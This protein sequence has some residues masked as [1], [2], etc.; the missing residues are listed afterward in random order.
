MIRAYPESELP[1]KKLDS[2]ISRL[3]DQLKNSSNGLNHVLQQIREQWGACS[4]ELA[5]SGTFREVKSSHL[6][7]QLE[8]VVE[9]YLM[10]SL[11]SP[12]F[13]LIRHVTAEQEEEWIKT[14]YSYRYYTQSDLGI[15]K[16]MQCEQLK[17]ISLLQSIVQCKT[18]LEMLLRLKDTTESISAEIQATLKD[19]YQ[20]TT[21]DLLDQLLYVILKCSQIPLIAILKYISEFH[22]VNSNTSILGYVYM[23]TVSMAIVRMIDSRLPISKLQWIGI[24]YE[25][26][27]Q[28]LELRV[29]SRA[30]TC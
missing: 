5:A 24:V 6:Q 18:P 30:P 10:E 13:R 2:F 15:S 1:L 26:K 27:Q 8:Q 20:L 4:F 11:Q 23:I 12:L 25:L 16:A 21:D 14:M 3:Q 17:A 22:F 9:S 28:L 7:V 19:S 29:S